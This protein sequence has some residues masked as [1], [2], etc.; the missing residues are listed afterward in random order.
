MATGAALLEKEPRPLFE[1]TGEFGRFFFGV[2]QALEDW[3]GEMPCKVFGVIS[4]ARTHRGAM[5]DST[6]IGQP[7]L[8]N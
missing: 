7:V 1:E 5:N 8:M 4:A 6:A 3:L 2:A